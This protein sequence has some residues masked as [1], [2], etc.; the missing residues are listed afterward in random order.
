MSGIVVKKS[1]DLID[2]QAQLLVGFLQE[3]GLPSENIIANA[4][5]RAIIGDNIQTLI[6]S[7]PDEVKKNATYLSKFVIGAGIGLFDYSLN[8]VWNEVVINL[9]RKA[10]LYGLD[11]FFDAAV[12]GSKAREY[13]NNEEDLSSLKDSVL[14]DTSRKLEL[15][16]DTT[17]K[18]LK[19]ILDM[20]NDT[21][22]SHPND[23]TINAYELLG[24]LQNCVNDVLNDNPTE[25]ALQVQAFI[26]NLKTTTDTLDAATRAAVEKRISELPSHL[27]GSL[28]R[29]VFGI[30]VAIE[31]DPVVR[32]N[33][34]LIAPALWNS[35]Q[36]DA[37]FKLGVVLEG[38]NINLYRDKHALGRQFFEVV[39][40]NSFR[41]PSERVIIVDE[42]IT[43]L[44]DKHNGWDN[45]HHEAP[46]A[47]QLYSY[48]PDQNSIFENL[49]MRLFK[50]VLMCRIGRGV[51]YYEGVSPGGRK[52][53]EAI[54]SVAGD[55]YAPYAMASL[56]HF[57]LKNKLTN[58]LCRKHAK[59]ALGF[60]R[61]NVINA[62]IIECLDYLIANIE[63][64]ASCVDSGDFKK[65]SQGYISWN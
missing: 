49:G 39:D 23:Y 47:A 16:S 17:Y 2:P 51:S 65:L 10:V 28:L 5:Q 11:I 29:T 26:K 25:A 57:E 1:N 18:K 30:Y 12:G 61:K 14:L 41:S 35:C 27:C 34:S 48:V 6:A 38:Y 7:I 46:V 50:V 13:Y 54:L 21:G 9:R 56:A 15:I 4:Q 59:A 43:E 36:D 60:I 19:H 42:L 22:I 8:A 33:I 64:S 32:K 24:Y 52:Y 44:L 20:R 55:K 63:A 40:G 3:M 45:F 62:R 37:K 53:Y 31:T 58:S